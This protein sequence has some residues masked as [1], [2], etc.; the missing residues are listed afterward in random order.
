M[1][2]PGTG[3]ITAPTVSFV[4][5]GGGSATATAVISST[6]VRVRFRDHGMYDVDLIML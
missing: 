1:T 4:G 3:Y 5:G 2:N 6:S